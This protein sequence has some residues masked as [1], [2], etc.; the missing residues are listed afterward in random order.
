[1]ADIP[2]GARLP[3][4]AACRADIVWAETRQRKAGKPVLMPVLMPVDP[5][6]SPRGNVMLH[7]LGDVW[8]AGVLGKNQAAGA[9][10]RGEKLH[11]SHLVTCADPE[12]FRRWS[13]THR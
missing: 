10:E 3:K 7:R 6:P 13:R 5:D 4:C 11:L 9:I 2:I 12:R 8:F 1:M